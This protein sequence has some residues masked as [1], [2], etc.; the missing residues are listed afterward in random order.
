MF[1][2]FTIRAREVLVGAQAEAIA[3]G[4]PAIGTEH[5]LL[6][7]LRDTSSLA[8]QVLADMDLDVDKVRTYIAGG[9]AR[10]TARFSGEMPISPRVKAALEAAASQADRLDKNFIGTEHLLL[11]LMIGAGSG[12]VQVVEALG[13]DPE[14]VC[15]SLLRAI[16]GEPEHPGTPLVRPSG[17]A[18]PPS[19][20]WYS[21]LI[22]S[23]S[24]AVRIWPDAT[25]A[26]RVTLNGG[27][28]CFLRAA[29]CVD[30][31]RVE[32]TCFASEEDPS[33]RRLIVVRYDAFRRVEILDHGPAWVGAAVAHGRTPGA[34]RP[35]GFGDRP[36]PN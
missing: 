10:T 36:G 7:L 5:L 19:T 35:S 25:V 15:V 24:S 14:V 20:R 17:P 29:R 34:H 28:R 12:A 27:E 2:R 6:G 9:S 18:I 16:S 33:A 22:L 3:L 11:G 13:A 31:D 21:A 8:G 30:G 26:V 1:E 4:R 23:L 32:L